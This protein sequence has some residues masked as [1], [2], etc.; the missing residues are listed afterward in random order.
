MKVANIMHLINTK[1]Q[2]PKE[3]NFGPPC[4]YVVCAPDSSRRHVKTKPIG[5]SSYWQ[6]FLFCRLLYNCGLTVVALKKHLIDLI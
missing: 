1:T 5:Y 6:Y 2:I 3:S 4:T